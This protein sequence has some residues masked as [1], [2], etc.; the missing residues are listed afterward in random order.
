MRK[1]RK[2]AFAFAALVSL[3]A[4]AQGPAKNLQSGFYRVQNFKTKRYAY[5]C[6]NRGWINVATTSADMGAIVLYTQSFH[7][8]LT[9]PAS[10]CYIETVSNK[11]NVYGQNTSLYDIIGHYVQIQD[12][13][14]IN[15]TAAYQITPLLAGTTNYLKDGTY[16]SFYGASSVAAPFNDPYNDTDNGKDGY[17]LIRD[18][19]YWNCISF[20]PNGDEYLG[21]AP[22]EA[23]EV[24]GK[25]YRPYV[26]GFDMTLLSPGMKAYYVYDIKTDAI[27]IKEINGTIPYNTPVIIECSSTKPASN[28]VNVSITKSPR[29]NG[30]RLTANY[31]CYGSHGTSAYTLYD[32]QTMRVLKVQD[33]KLV[34]GT[35][36]SDDKISTTVLVRNYEIDNVQYKDEK[37]CLQAN[38]SYL[39]VAADFP[40]NVPV[41]TEREYRLSHYT[42]GASNIVD[43]IIK[44]SVANMDA[45]FNGDGTISI[46]DL[47]LYIEY[48]KNK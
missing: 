46:A 12:A 3:G 19:Y 15:N 42:G 13:K 21:V 9:D 45:D 40:D 25:Y 22:N 11:H 44:K 32:P 47:A 2:L 23:M 30:N 20:T 1:N 6:D 38:S 4:F 5:V 18:C 48:L 29:I 41:M 7:D 27:I 37:Q 16:S 31:F 39:K 10:L 43:M 28:R 26:I 17:T 24:G 14:T 36:A 33:G 34:F 35:V 8:R